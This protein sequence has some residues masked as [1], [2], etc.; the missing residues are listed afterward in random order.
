M[1]NPKLYIKKIGYLAAT[2][3]FDENTEVVLLLG[4]LLKKD[5]GS[6]DMFAVAHALDCLANLVTEELANVLVTDVYEL[7]NSS[8]SYIRKKSVLVL[9]KM[10][11]RYPDALRPSFKRLQDKLNDSD[12]PVEFKSFTLCCDE[13]EPDAAF[14]LSIQTLLD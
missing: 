8:S 12:N 5:M 11:L 4:N 13:M 1:S 10:F 6:K 2:Q 3:S 7:L 9:Y 14:P